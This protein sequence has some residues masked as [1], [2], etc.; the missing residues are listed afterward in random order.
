MLVLITFGV[1]LELGVACS[2]RSTESNREEPGANAGAGGASLEAAGTRMPSNTSEVVDDGSAGSQGG[3]G[4]PG[5]QAGGAPTTAD[6]YH[7]GSSRLK[8]L[9]ETSC[10]VAVIGSELSPH[11]ATVGIVSFSTSLVGLSAAE[12]QFGP[13]PAYGLVAP[14]DLKEEGYRTLLLGMRQNSTYHYRVAVSDGSSVCYGDDR[15]MATGSLNAAALAQ[16]STSDGAAPGFIV[17]SRDGQAVIYDKHGQLVWAYDM[18]NVFSVHMSWD[19]QYMI[20]RDPG[21]FDSGDGGVFYRVKMDGSGFTTLDA[22][23]GDHHDFTAIPEGIAYLAKPDEGE[24]DWVYEASI[25]ITDGLPMFDSWQIYQYFPDEGFLEGPEICHANRIHYSLEKNVYTVSD[26]NKDAL[27][28]FSKSGAPLTSI[29]KMPTGNWTHHVQAESAG[30]GGDWHVQHGHHLYAEDKLVV[31]SNDSSG[32]PAML[33]YTLSGNHASLDWKYDGAGASSIQGDVQRLPN[34]NFL[35]TANFSGTMVEVGPDG[36][37]EMGRYVLSGPKGPLYGFT[38]SKH[39]PTLYG[40][41]P[42]W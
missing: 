2:T 5:S 7:D 20:G 17:T 18:W 11:I 1:L 12:I 34:G 22:P 16:A 21:P 23:G 4:S 41:P 24:C 29:G 36:K 26:R 40:S 32:G 10:N 9:P 42:P 8:G 19:G 35:V 14:V 27:A 13:D 15:T 31:F 39:R 6:Q 30:P 25:D 3:G 28:V 33:H 37:A 38:Y